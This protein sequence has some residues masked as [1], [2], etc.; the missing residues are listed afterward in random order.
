MVDRKFK[1][2]KIY[3]MNVLNVRNPHECLHMP[4]FLKQALNSSLTMP[5]EAVS[6]GWFKY[7]PLI[8][9][10]TVTQELPISTGR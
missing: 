5:L 1:R 2:K 4:T 3:I 9:E 7:F 10:P 6:E 8:K